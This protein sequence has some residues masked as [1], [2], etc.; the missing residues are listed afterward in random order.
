MPASTNA[1]AE[2]MLTNSKLTG[3]NTAP[4]SGPMTWPS[5]DAEPMA[6]YTLARSRSGSM[7]ERCARGRIGQRSANG[8]HKRPGQ[9]AGHVEGKCKQQK[10]R[11]RG[12]RTR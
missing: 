9:Y 3:S 12:P 10:P 4:S 2:T 11:A 8:G 6:A 1:A 7:S 5:Q